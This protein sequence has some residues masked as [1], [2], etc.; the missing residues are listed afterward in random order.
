MAEACLRTGRHYLDITG[1]LRV[2]D[3]L[4]GLDGRARQAGVMLLPGMGFDVAPT[5]CLALYL[6]QKMPEAVRL[7]L[8][9]LSLGG[10]A[11]HGTLLTVAESLPLGGAVRENGWLVSV[12]YAARTRQVDFGRGPREL[13]LIPLGDLVTAFTSTGIPNIETYAVLPRR[14]LRLMYLVRPFIGL[15]GWQPVQSLLRRAVLS[16][17]TGPTAEA[18]QTGRSLAW[19]EVVDAQGRTLAALLE[20]PET[21]HLTARVLLRA[22]E[23]VLAGEAQPGFQTPAM[24]FGADFIL[25]FEGVSRKDLI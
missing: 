17:P 22:A 24:L 23:R 1:E 8:A 11:S 16:Q 25:E 13:A 12:P 15:A 14:L 10:G 9:A 5:D 7:S 2:F 3:Y 4:A 21:Y 20:M 19:G 18:R 6:K